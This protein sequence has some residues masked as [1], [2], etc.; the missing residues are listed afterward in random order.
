MIAEDRNSASSH[1]PYAVA[2]RDLRRRRAAEGIGI[3][4]LFVPVIGSMLWFRAHPSPHENTV[5]VGLAM[6][7][8]VPVALGGYK[9]NFRCPRCGHR[10]SRSARQGTNN[11]KCVSCG[12]TI[13]TLRGG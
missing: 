13:G 11:D 8:V 2:W 1:D 7:M 4:V 10:F 12:L 3:L 6:L 9:S 5:I